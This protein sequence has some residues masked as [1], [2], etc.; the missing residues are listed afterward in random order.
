ML[1]YLLQAKQLNKQ[2]VKSKHMINIYL[3]KYNTST[4]KA[5]K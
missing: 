2:A 1:I 4:S 3:Y 5:E